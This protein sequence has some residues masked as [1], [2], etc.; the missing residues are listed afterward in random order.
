MT[1]KVLDRPKPEALLQVVPAPPARKRWILAVGF[2][3]ALGAGLAAWRM[4]AAPRMA[5]FGTAPVKRLT[6]AKT[7]NATGTLQ[8]VTTVQV[9][10]QVSGTISELDADFNSQVK[11]D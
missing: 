6:I 4:T 1:T 5:Q 3:L 11:K 7:I 8:A 10:T 2:V 9:G